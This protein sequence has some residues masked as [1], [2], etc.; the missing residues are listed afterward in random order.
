MLMDEAPMAPAI[1]FDN[2]GHSFL[3]NQA[4][5]VAL[6]DLNLTVAGGAITCILGPSG[7][8]KSTIINLAA[9]FIKPTHGAVRLDGQPIAGPGPD[10]GVVF[11]EFVLFPWLTV[12]ENIQAGLRFQHKDPAYIQKTAEELTH[13]VGLE[14]FQDAYPGTLSGGMQQRVALARTR[15]TRPRVLL[16]DE[17]FGA[18]DAQT[19]QTMQSLLLRLWEMQKQTIL[20]VTHDIDEA[21]YLGDT[22]VIVTERPASVSRVFE[23]QLPRPRTRNT[24]AADSYIRTKRDVMDLIYSREP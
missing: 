6:R 18:L 20:F 12:R 13:S 17:P 16:M 8:G 5:T 7:S 3:A 22:I 2:V 1:L 10:R 15:A 4:V 9:G 23:P 21:L 11:Q 19:R 14:E 24:F